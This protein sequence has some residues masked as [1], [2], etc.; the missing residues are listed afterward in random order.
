MASTLWYSAAI[1]LLLFAQVFSP[2]ARADVVSLNGD[3]FTDKVKEKDT[4]W[5]I[6]FCVPWC[7]Y[8]KKLGSLWDDLGVAVEGEDGIEIGEVDC[9]TSK[10][11]CT[12]V[13][14]H[15]YPTFKLFYEGD[16]IAKYTGPRDV[17][18]LKA[19]VLD[20]A[21]KAARGQLD[22]DDASL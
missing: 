19:F 8:C 21:E 3:T 5:F 14:I 22:G 17:Q 10:L 12:K 16:E 18:S 20:E 15:A 4:L 6:K 2:T 9:S 1:F 7:K 11:L 13:N